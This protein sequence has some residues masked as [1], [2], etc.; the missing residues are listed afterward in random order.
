[1]A[2]IYQVTWRWTGFQGA[3]GFTNFFYDATTDTPVQALAAVTKSKIFWTGVQGILQSIVH[4]DPVTDV[5]V[6]SDN[7]GTLVNIYTVSGVTG[8]TGGAG[9]TFAGPSGA[10]VDWLTATVHGGR[11]MMGKTFLVPVASSVYDNDGTIT[12]TNVTAIATAAENMRTASGPAF[13]IWGRPT[14]VKP[15][16]TPPTIDRPGLWGPATGSRVPDKSVVLTSRRD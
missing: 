7:D 12:G 6:I 14:Y 4:V 1:M 13:G 2:S 11:S 15:A 9:G 10:M 5:R 3:P 16:T 8:I